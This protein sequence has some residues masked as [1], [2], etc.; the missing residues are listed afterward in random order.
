VNFAPGETT[1]VE[2]TFEAVPTGTR[3]TLRHSG[4]AAL[5]AG[6]PVRHGQDGPSFLRST[7]LWWGELMTS[8]REFLAVQ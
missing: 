4:W 2:V 3:V 5:R 7:G 6:H 8:Y 1:R